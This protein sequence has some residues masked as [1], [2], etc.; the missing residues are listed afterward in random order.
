MEH[1]FPALLNEFISADF[2]EKVRKKFHFEKEQAAQIRRVAE[3]MLPF[4]REEAFWVRKAYSVERRLLG[5]YGTAYECAAM[6]LGRGIDLLQESYSEKGLLLES[7]I[8]EV[9]AGELLMRGYDA[10]NKYIAEHTDRHVARYHFPGSENAFP[11]E[12]LPE[13]LNDLTQEITCNAAFC[14]Q[15]KKSVVFVAEL[16]QDETV[17]CRG[18]CIGCGSTSCPNRVEEND[19]IRKRMADMPLT[20]G[21]SRI[22]GT[23][24]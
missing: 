18:I 2:L 3:E 10:Y 22:F 23:V 6:S 24:G 11:L 7:Y 16:T 21:Y 8:V 5:D 4:M 15:P 14:M 20:Y 13:L 1:F 17:R 12:M 19:L 9:L